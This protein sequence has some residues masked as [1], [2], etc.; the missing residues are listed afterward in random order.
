MQ[1]VLV[2]ACDLTSDGQ[3]LGPM[4]I[5]RLERALRYVQGT[6][7]CL[8]VAASWSPRH[9]KQPVPMAEMM[10]VWLRARGWHKIRVAQAKVF[11]TR[12]ELNAAW[13][14][15]PLSS[16]ISDPLHLARVRILVERL[17]GKAY[18]EEL[19]YVATD[20]MAITRRGQSLEMI[21][22]AFVRYCPFWLQD[23][24]IWLQHHTLLRHLNLSY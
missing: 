12:G 8:V 20:A 11:N 21:K 19:E 2:L 17:R 18:A 5:V 3:T 13:Q 4:T 16:I 9:P 14:L 7:T 6:D 15:G 23:A 10:A 22:R 24:V 1:Y